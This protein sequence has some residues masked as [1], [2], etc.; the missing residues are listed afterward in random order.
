M[1]Y[2][3]ID[4]DGTITTHAYPAIGLDIGAFTVLKK[5]QEA[6]HSLILF[7]MRH[8]KTLDEAVAYCKENGIEFFGINENPDQDWSDSRKVY[9]HLYI[10]DAAL[11]APTL[12]DYNT[13]RRYIN[14]LLVASRLMQLGLIPLLS[15]TKVRFVAEEAGKYDQIYFW[16]YESPV[17][18]KVRL[19]TNPKG[20]GCDF[21]ANISHLILCDQTES[22]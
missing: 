19:K 15:G 9:A 7:T 12:V 2:I 3:A 10:D 16:T 17:G 20:C 13:G 1:A 11:G 6:G 21:N 8:G 14:W 22:E 5:L 18:G 4:F